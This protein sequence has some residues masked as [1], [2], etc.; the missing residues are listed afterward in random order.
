MQPGLY[1]VHL[2]QTQAQSRIPVSLHLPVGVSAAP[3]VLWVP[4]HRPGRCIWAAFVVSASTSVQLGLVMQ[5]GGWWVVQSQV[6][7]AVQQVVRQD[8]R[9]GCC[10]SSSAA[11]SPCTISTSVS[12]VLSG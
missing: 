8:L 7:V 10:Q 3:P 2:I 5:L 11:D 1:V 6:H 9:G 12:C 4:M